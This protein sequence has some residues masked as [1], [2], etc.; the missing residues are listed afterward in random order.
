MAEDVSDITIAVEAAGAT[1]TQQEIEGVEQSI[2]EAGEGMADTADQMSGLQRQMQGLGTALVA[3][4]ATVTAGLLSQV[5]V[6][7][8]VF[9]GLA[10]IMEAVAFQMD[11]RLRPALQPVA[12]FLFQLANAIFEADGAAGSFVG[13]IG[14]VIALLTGIVAALTPVL[15]VSGALSA[16]WNGLATIGGFVVKAIS[17][18]ISGSTTAAVAIGT[19]IGIIAVA[20]LEITGVLD[21]IKGLANWLSNL[22]PSAVTDFVL[23][24]SSIFL[25]ILATVGAAIVGFVQGF[26]Q[27]G[28]QEGIKQ[29]VARTQDV[30]KIFANAWT[31]LIGSGGA[32][33]KAIGGFVVDVLIAF[34]GLVSD[35]VD[36]AV[37]IA[38]GFG[39]ALT[40]NTVR[41]ANGAID[42]V[43]AIVEKIT[44]L[45]DDMSD[46]GSDLIDE[47]VNG[48][49]NNLDKVKD[50]IKNVAESARK[51]LPGSPAETGPLSDLDQT[52][53]G[54]VSEFAT[55]IEANVGQVSGA[56]TDLATETAEGNARGVFGADRGRG[57]PTIEMDGRSLTEQDGRYRRDQTQRRGR[58]G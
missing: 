53:P 42:I 47:F 52:G 28:L 12:N 23:A 24:M 25:G 5:P 56:T 16:V 49:K 10:A 34:A 51:R 45:V 9:G 46:F 30:L 13:A 22:L 7:G 40:N 29:A 32:I 39:E 57:K 14:N 37:D 6:L 48:I 2:D 4:L 8:E 20:I 17:G 41:A 36:K 26:L 55:G 21:A 31:S 27:G 50:A 33:L 1:E 38:V 44:E 54:L 18:I 35:I 58:N 15:G 43:N 3:G 11:Q 19:L